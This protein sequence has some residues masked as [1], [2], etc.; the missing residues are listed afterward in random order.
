MGEVAPKEVLFEKDVSISEK[1]KAIRDCW[2]I[3]GVECA[4]M[5]GVSYS[6][7]V[8]WEVGSSVPNMEDKVCR[9]AVRRINRLFKAQ[10]SGSSKIPYRGYRK[11]GKQDALI[12]FILDESRAAV[13]IGSSSQK[14]VRKRFLQL[15][16]SNAFPLRLLGTISGSRNQERDMHGIFR[17]Y[18]ISK[19][20]EWFYLQGQFYDY[21]VSLGF[22][23]CD[24]SI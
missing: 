21:L 23:C 11:K 7:W 13:K 22:V 12:Y 8:D 6:R 17:K 16:C 2:N 19:S 18:R 15:Q 4:N 3:T 5:V 14:S 10:L 24:Y 9:D 1:M 20:N